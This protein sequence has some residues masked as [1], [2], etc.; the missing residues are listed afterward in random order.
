MIANQCSTAYMLPFV[1]QLHIYICIYNMNNAPCAMHHDIYSSSTETSTEWPNRNNRA[2]FTD[3]Q[4]IEWIELF[5][6]IIFSFFNDVKKHW[7]WETST[8]E[9]WKVI[10]PSIGAMKRNYGMKKSEQKE[11]HNQ[12]N[13]NKFSNTSD[14]SNRKLKHKRKLYST[15][16]SNDGESNERIR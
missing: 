1:Y 13:M 9:K 4:R 8:M 14:S 5:N 3:F 12:Q 15:S 6:L 2:S 11:K 7:D 16:F 10:V